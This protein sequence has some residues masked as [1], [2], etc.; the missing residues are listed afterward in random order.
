MPAVLLAQQ[1]G[2]GALLHTLHLAGFDHER[3]ETAA[4]EM[5]ALEQLGRGRVSSAVANPAA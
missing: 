1:V 3:S 4:Q 5:F 2:T